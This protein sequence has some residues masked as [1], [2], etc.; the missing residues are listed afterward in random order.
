MCASPI[1]AVRDRKRIFLE[2]DPG[3]SQKIAGASFVKTACIRRYEL[4]GTLYLKKKNCKQDF[5][6]AKFLIF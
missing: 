3:P 5:N 6:S 2:D 1:S 4:K